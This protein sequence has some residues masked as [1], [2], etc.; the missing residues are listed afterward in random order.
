MKYKIIG[1]ILPYF[2][3][4]VGLDSSITDVAV[5]EEGLKKHLV[6]QN[7]KDVLI[8]FDKIAE[9]ISKP[10]YVGINPKEKTESMELIKRYDTNILLALKVDRKNDCYYIPTM[11][12]VSEYKVKQRLYS[13][14]LKKVDRLFKE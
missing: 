7:H 1:K 13:G 14:R 11:Y 5:F 12:T 2:K 8:Y 9:I 10:D 4:L 6:K 3:E